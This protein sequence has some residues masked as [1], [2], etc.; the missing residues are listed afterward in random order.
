[1]QIQCLILIAIFAS[2][3]GCNV[4]TGVSPTETVIANSSERDFG[5]IGTWIPVP[6][7]DFPHDVATNE[8]KVA[9]DDGYSVSIDDQFGDTNE[10]LSVSF[11]THEISKDHPHAIVEIELTADEK[12]AYRRLAI[13]AVKGDHLYLWMIDGKK[14]GEHL[15][16]D[17]V[18]AVIE[19]FTFLS[20]VR[21]DPEN[22]LES[23]SKHSGDIVGSAQVFRRKP[24]IGR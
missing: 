7:E 2:F 14:V 1:M 10:K 8:M 24:N 6:N 16:N 21:C 17:G 15:Y 3:A 18:A 9:R 22:L 23:L 19:H 11:R 13:A 20:T 5:F 4:Q 12:I